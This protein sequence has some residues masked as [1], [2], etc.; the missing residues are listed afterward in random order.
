[1]SMFALSVLQ[2]GSDQGLV[3]GLLQ[4]SCPN[5]QVPSQEAKSFIASKQM[6][7]TCSSQ[8]TSWWMVTPRYLAEVTDATVWFFWLSLTFF[9]SINSF[10]IAQQIFSPSFFHHL[11]CEVVLFFL[12]RRWIFLT[13]PGRK[14]SDV[15]G[16]KP[17]FG[18]NPQVHSRYPPIYF[19]HYSTSILAWY[20][21][22]KNTNFF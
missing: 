16:R 2:Y 3:C 10:L 22:K 20:L 5:P 7:F 4:F 1:M 18:L 8:L 13:C 17:I 15:Y 14:P 11:I 19:H 21:I 9:Q 12:H 6:L